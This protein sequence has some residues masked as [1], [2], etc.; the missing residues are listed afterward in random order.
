MAKN[1][2]R[3][4]Q[5]TVALHVITSLGW[6]GQALAL[7]SLL[8]VAMS[9]A[10]PDTR[11]AATSMAHHLDLSVLAV[12]ANASA[13][14]GIMLAASTSWGFFRHRWVWIKFGLTLVQLYAGIFLLSDALDDAT[15]AARD[16]QAAP[17][18]ALVIGTAAMVGALAFQTWLSV[19]KPGRAAPGR[20]KPPT[21]SERTFAVTAVVV[22]ADIVLSV[23]LGNPAPLFSLVTI[24]VR[25]GS[26]TRELRGRVLVQT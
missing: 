1:S 12:L 26:R 9:T 11:V 15:A 25:L 17:P 7:A 5:L 10:D 21:A 19:A 8:S 4:R 14:T 24:A 18:V 16:V 22:L 20:A 2:R 23:L 6:M 3:W 13:F